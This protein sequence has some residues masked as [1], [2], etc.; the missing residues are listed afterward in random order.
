MKVYERK[1]NMF[2]KGSDVI[3]R[4]DQVEIV[5]GRYSSDI[6]AKFYFHEVVINSVNMNI[7]MISTTR[8]VLGVIYNARRIVDM[9]DSDV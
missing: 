8:K 2:T 6:I 9:R 4:N 7:T 1:Y 5:D 3:I